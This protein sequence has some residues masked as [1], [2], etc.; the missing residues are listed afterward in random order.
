MFSCN[1]LWIFVLIE[2]KLVMIRFDNGHAGSS[3]DCVCTRNI[4]S[5][6]KK[7]ELVMIKLSVPS[8]TLSVD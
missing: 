8:V 7:S 5:D 2:N 6:N 3:Y 4:L 1:N